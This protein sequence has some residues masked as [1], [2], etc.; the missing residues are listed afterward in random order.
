[1]IA[2]DSKRLLYVLFFFSG[3]SALIYQ[4]VWIRMFG[5]VFGVSAFAMATVLT[6]FM[7]GLGF[8]NFYFAK[9]AD[10]SRDPLRLYALLELGIG[11]FGLIFPLLYLALK[12]L[13][14]H[15]PTGVQSSFPQMTALRFVL[16]LVALM[17]PTTLMGGTLPVL[18]RI[19]VRDLH[20]IG[21]RIGNLYSV[22]N[23]GAMAGCLAAGFVVI[24]VAGVRG[25]VYVAA[26][27]NIVIAFLAWRM[28]KTSRL[29]PLPGEKVSLVT[30][31]PSHDKASFSTPVVRLV[32]VLIGL[33]GFASLAYELIWTRILS[34]SVL[35]NSVYSF[36]IVAAVF[37]L[38]LSL[39]SWITALV[40][41]KRKDALGSFAL[42]EIGIGLTAIMFLLLFSHVPAMDHSLLPSAAFG[43]WGGTI[44]RDLFLSVVIML[45][46]ATLMGM[47]FPTAVKIC[48]R[49]V[50]EAAH[51]VGIVGGV[52]II[53]SILGAFCGGFV[54]I[55]VFGM[56]HSITVLAFVNILAGVAAVLADRLLRWRFRAAIAAVICAACAATPAL[57]PHQALYW[58]STTATHRNEWLQYYVEDY[59]ATVA[60]V[61]TQTADGMAKCLEVDGIPVAGTDFML[62]TTQKVQA[63]IP[64]LLYES[65]NVGRAKKVL[66]VGLGSGGTSWSAMQHV[67][68][69]VTCVELVPGVAKAAAREFA[70]ENHAVFDS[71]RYRLIIGDGRNHVFATKE[72]YD[73]ILTESVHP[74]YASNASLYTRDYF[75]ACRMRLTES[76]VFSVW[77]PIYRISPGDFKTVMATFLSV[78]P[79]ASVWFTPNSLSRQVLL[80]GTMKELR[81]DVAR[82]NALVRA[83]GIASDLAKVRL[84]DPVKLLDCMIMSEEDMKDFS[85]GAAFHTDDRPVL[86]FSA[87]RS[88]DDVTTWKQNLA[89][90]AAYKR[91]RFEACVHDADSTQTRRSMARYDSADRHVLAGILNHFDN[92]QAAIGQYRVAQGLNPSDSSIGFLA[93]DVRRSVLDKINLLQSSG[94]TGEASA[95]YG[96]LLCAYPDDFDLVAGAARWY[97]IVGRVDSAEALLRGFLMHHP[98]S[99]DAFTSL[100]IV[101][102]N[103]KQWDKALAALDN[104]LVLDPRRAET[105]NA[106]AIAY[107]GKG[108]YGE[109][110]SDMNRAIE[111][112]PKTPNV[113]ENRSYVYAHMSEE[114][115]PASQRL[116]QQEK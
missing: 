58:R 53:G 82:W 95:L 40:I 96:T 27:L 89:A 64:L 6:S 109:A 93:R 14:L 26:G 18:S 105:Y 69:T 86:E 34:A 36:C 63:H 90:I 104:A 55:S 114:K 45:V 99:A 10:R 102:V 57:L 79:H 49:S 25:T 65:Q 38:G 115:N 68:S 39:G 37:I 56:Y 73:A 11:L 19:F 110:L 8:G 98:R 4:V 13:C 72:R 54:L 5:L 12:V 61:E 44:A 41:D 46:P 59:A 1:M 88:A 70:E 29:S 22:N 35:G 32:L 51:G 62:R 17:V 28:S 74:V 92:Q 23:A 97:G 3:A 43:D 50:N 2:P 81:I 33:E 106:R 76:G 83:P 101:Y 67:A 78:F 7:A 52:N 66:A 16:S 94:R 111:I 107:A 100:G 42:I 87:P 116:I 91:S 85:I 75:A 103:N 15:L 77:L 31:P 48:T 20:T 9:I 30:I 113:Y 24:L 112:D 47:A 80:I 108:L 60:V 71:S 84:D 21:R